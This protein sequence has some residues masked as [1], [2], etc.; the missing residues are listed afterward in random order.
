MY[1]CGICEDISFDQSIICKGI[2]RSST[3]ALG[4]DVSCVEW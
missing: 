2:C 1:Q 4:G 3:Q